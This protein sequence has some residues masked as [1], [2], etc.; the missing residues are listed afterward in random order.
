MDPSWLGRRVALY[1]PRPALSGTYAELAT[2]P[3]A[4]LV[5]L[6]DGLD[7]VTAAAVLA[8]GLTAYLLIHRAARI[9][10]DQVVLIHAAAG[11]VGLIATQLMPRPPRRTG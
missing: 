11:G 8:Q 4:A 7:F 3:D 5:A 6:P 1:G 10:A 9:R 2:C